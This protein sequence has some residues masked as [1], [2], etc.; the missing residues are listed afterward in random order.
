V[1]IPIATTA[2]VRERRLQRRQPEAP[3]PDPSLAHELKLAASAIAL[4]E[5]GG[6]PRVTLVGMRAG[7]EL[8]SRALA[9]AS[10][11]PVLV[12][13]RWWPEGDALDLVVE[14]HG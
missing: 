9:M 10:P 4:V 12:R 3:A 8:V 5:A 2:T 1:E 13:A 7:R 11:A 6:A 14:R